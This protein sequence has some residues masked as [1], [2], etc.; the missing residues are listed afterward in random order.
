MTAKEDEVKMTPEEARMIWLTVVGSDWIK[1]T[2]LHESAF[3][4]AN[5]AYKVLSNAGKMERDFHGYR[6]KLNANRR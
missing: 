2:D 5:K 1:F 3:D 6:V 4:M